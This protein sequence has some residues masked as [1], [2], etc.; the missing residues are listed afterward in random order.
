MSARGDNVL[1]W[2]IVAR[3]GAGAPGACASPA[4][5]E[6][7][8][9]PPAPNAGEQAEAVERAIASLM[10]LRRVLPVPEADAPRFFRQLDAAAATLR[11]LEVLERTL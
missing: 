4:S 5:G 8:L 6:G 3:D 7:F 11:R 2:P 1:D 10:Q 9:P